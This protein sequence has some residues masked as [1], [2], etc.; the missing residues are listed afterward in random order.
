VA[1]LLTGGTSHART[2]GKIVLGFSQIGAESTWR[3]ANTE[4]VKKAAAEAGVFLNFSDA[5]QKQANQ[6][7]AIKTF[8]MQKV[9]V[10]AI[11]PV[12]ETGWHSV[13]VQAKQAK[14]PVI[15]FDRQIDEKDSSLYTTLIGPDFREEGRRAAR[16]LI[17]EASRLHPG[18]EI[19][20]IELR[21]TDGSTPAIGRTQG[22][23]EVLKNHP[24]F[25]I[26]RSVEGNFMEARGKEI[27]EAVL[28]EER[29]RGRPIHA[30]FAHNDDMALGAIPSIKAMGLSPGKD[31]VIVSVDA[32]NDAVNALKRG[33]I[34]CTV[35]CSPLLG[36][37]LMTAVKELAEGKQLPRKITTQET[38]F[39]LKLSSQELPEREY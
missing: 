37:Q 15:L 2:N 28:K 16:C 24:G 20:I 9:D 33:E 29:S 6:I 31:I 35:E 12:V 36:P 5:Q 38:V 19:N 3:I 8:I 10:I 11:A 22:I 34:N 27:M 30:L 7:R 32:T 13:L 39:S 17:E 1:L 23:S 4:S 14:I 18:K 21:G 26:I 25:K